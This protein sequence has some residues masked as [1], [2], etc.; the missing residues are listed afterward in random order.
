MGQKS[1]LKLVAMGCYL[2]V[3][4]QMCGSNVVNLYSHKILHKSTTHENAA[5]VTVG[6]SIFE[7]LSIGLS[8]LLTQY[9][10]VK[11]LWL[12]GNFTVPAMLVFVGLG[13]FME[14]VYISSAAICVFLLTYSMTIGPLTYV[15]V[16]HIVPSEVMNIPMATH[17]T[18]MLL[19]AMFFPPLFQKIGVDN[20]IYIEAVV[21]TVIAV[22]N[23]WVIQETRGLT[24]DEAMRKYLGNYNEDSCKN[25]GSE[26]ELLGVELGKSICGA[27]A[28]STQ[29]IEK[30]F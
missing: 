18:M 29:T 17:K 19:M 2:F 5:M 20:V 28:V 22:M 8:L 13:A 21:I 16:N 6:M 24:R 14:N 15:I 23:I 9:I 30:N 1:N 11:T 26:N 12:F 10:N 27:T 4:Q 3:C 7:L 25:G